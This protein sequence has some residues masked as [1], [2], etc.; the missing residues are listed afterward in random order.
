[1]VYEL[2]YSMQFSICLKEIEILNLILR[3]IGCS[4]LEDVLCCI[5]QV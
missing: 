1:M 2:C 4:V 5:V 3:D